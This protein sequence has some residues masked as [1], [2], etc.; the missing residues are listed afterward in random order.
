MVDRGDGGGV[1]GFFGGAV[2]GVGVNDGGGR[3]LGGVIASVGVASVAF[4][5]VDNVVKF[6]DCG[7]VWDAVGVD[8]GEDEGEVGGG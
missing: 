5:F 6:G 3:F 4:E 7:C 2:V 1:G 8:I